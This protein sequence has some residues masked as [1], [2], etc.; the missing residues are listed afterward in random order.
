MSPYSYFSLSS[1]RSEVI[2]AGSDKKRRFCN[3]DVLKNVQKFQIFS[4]LKI[5][6][7]CGQACSSQSLS[8]DVLCHPVLLGGCVTYCCQSVC[9]YLLTPIASSGFICQPSLNIAWTQTCI[10]CCPVFPLGTCEAPRFY[11][12]W[13]VQFDSKV[14]GRFA[15]F[16]IGHACPLLVVVK[17]L[18][19][20]TALSGS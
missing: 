9:V 1:K 18:E 8:C 4:V 6:I 14:M 13:P 19:P 17:R 5:K 11:S 10:S 3:S 20:L 2:C 12:N 7:L 15:N 16:R